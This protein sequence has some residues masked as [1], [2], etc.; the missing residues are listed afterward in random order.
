MTP[1]V[2][3]P[4]IDAVVAVG[5]LMLMTVSCGWVSREASFHGLEIL[6]VRR[7]DRSRIAGDGDR[8]ALRARHLVRDEAERA[9]LVGDGF[10]LR[11]GRGR[12]HEDQHAVTLA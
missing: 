9:N 8:D 3:P 11:L 10:D 4:M 12:M 6:E 1:K 7:I 2:P 5:V